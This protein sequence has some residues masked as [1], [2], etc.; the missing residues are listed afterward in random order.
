MEF[1]LQNGLYFLVVAVMVAMMFRRGGGGCC[2]GH[3]HGN[4]KQQEPGNYG[5]DSQEGKYFKATALATEYAIDPVCGMR[6]NTSTGIRHTVNG[7]TYY[8]CSESCRR[9][10]LKNN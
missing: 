8:F 4:H 2:G 9:S 10:F 1:I 3:E 6:V 5:D 7:T